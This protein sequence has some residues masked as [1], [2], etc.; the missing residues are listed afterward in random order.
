MKPVKNHWHLQ[1]EWNLFIYCYHCWR[2]YK[3]FTDASYIHHPE[4]DPQLF[5]D[6]L[7]ISLF[8]DISTL[9]STAA[10]SPSSDS[11]RWGCFSGFSSIISNDTTDLL[12]HLGKVRQSH[13]WHCIPNLS[14]STTDCWWLVFRLFD[15]K[16]EIFPCLFDCSR[17]Q[18]VMAAK[19][20]SRSLA[21][22]SWVLREGTWDSQGKKRHSKTEETNHRL[23]QSW[24]RPGRKV[25]A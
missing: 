25:T 4:T 17:L 3:I 21:S 14:V 19:L 20:C 7:V 24:P 13:Q 9:S 1:C 18:L 2:Y 16:T 22:E 23:L 11:V 6:S 12:F 10:L 8:P 5:S 15:G